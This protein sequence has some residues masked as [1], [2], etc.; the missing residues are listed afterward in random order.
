MTRCTKRF[1]YWPALGLVVVCLLASSA[2]AATE[3]HHDLD[4]NH[5]LFGNLD[6]DDVPGCNDPNNVNFACGPTAAVNSFAFLQR[7][8]PSIYGESLIPDT[9]GNDMI[10]YQEMIDVA[11][12][13]EDPNFMDCAA[14][15]GGTTL[16]PDPNNGIYGGFIT[17]KQKYIEQQAPGTTIFKNQGFPNWDFLYGELW[18]ME[19]VEL[20]VGF[21][22]PNGMRIGGHYVTLTK[23]W[24][25]DTNMDDHVDPNEGGMI[26]FVDPADGML[27]MQS[28]FQLDGRMDLF[29][30]FAVGGL[31]AFTRID[32]AISESPIPEPATATLVT[33]GMSALVVRRR[34]RCRSG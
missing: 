17:G 28:L 31:V 24:W 25:E 8:F 34:R 11:V 3:Y 13:L 23:F 27:K 4:P 1:R 33:L 30:D 5:T 7:K 29:T 20:L 22:D 6:Q 14:C 21:Y 15:H 9:N 2:S 32:W 10:D 26:G 12:I 16:F 19:D 18:D